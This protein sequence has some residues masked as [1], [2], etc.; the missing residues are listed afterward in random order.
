ML[1]YLHAFHAG[2]HADVLKHVILQL[3]LEYITC[4]NRPF[5]Y[6]DTHAGAG[7]YDLLADR[8]QQNREYAT[9]IGRLWELAPERV[10]ELLSGYLRAVRALNPDGALRRYPG[11]PWLAHA[12][13]RAG[14]RALLF[15]LHTHEFR[16]LQALFA[17]QRQV[18]VAQEDGFHALQAVLP[19]AERRALI[20][21]DPPYEVKNDYRT[22]VNT[23]AAAYRKFPGGMYL[24][25]YPVVN[26]AAL[27]R[28]EHDMA[29]SGMR[30]VWLFELSVQAGGAGM[31]GSGMI[32]INPPWQ[33]AQQ[34]RGLLPVLQEVLANGSGKHRV[35]CLA[36]E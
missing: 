19:P 29:D 23:L 25:W 5:L 1:S 18:R 22:V 32:V 28:L 27:Q 17:R 13:L 7:R 30:D 34:L 33:L 20:L 8:A 26:R 24:A 9:G 10:P 16:N 35:V 15:E 2:N 21:V 36:G 14:D 6:V 3:A 12:A 31:S 4:K 11:S